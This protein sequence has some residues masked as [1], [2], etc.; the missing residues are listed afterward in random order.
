[1]LTVAEEQGLTGLAL[2]SQVQHAFYRLSEA[3]IAGLIERLREGARTRHVIYLH[4]GVLDPIRILPCP[5]AVLPAQLS[6]I[7]AV[8]LILQQAIKRLPA[9]Y[10]GDSTVR[11][12]LRLPDAEERWLRTHSLRGP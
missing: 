6:Y 12:I 7:H 11:D 3:T 1:M 5:L 8:T 10:F 4:D 9:L 2:A